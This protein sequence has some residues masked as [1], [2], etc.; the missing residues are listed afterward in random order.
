MISMAEYDPVGSFG[1]LKFSL[2]DVQVSRKPSTLKSNVG[3]MFIEKQIPMRNA[4]DIILQIS[5]VITGLSRTSGQTLSAAIEADRTSLIALE[6]GFKHT[7]SDGK[8]NN[9][10]VAIVPGTLVWPD[11]ANRQQ[12]ESYKFSMQIIQW[13]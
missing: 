7:W 10:Q 6:D 1:D 4:V 3:K 12:G 2:S 8:H 11:E 9:I 5:G 13:Q